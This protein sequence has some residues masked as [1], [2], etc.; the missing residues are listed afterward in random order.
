MCCRAGLGKLFKLAEDWEHM[1]ELAVSGYD[2]SGFKVLFVFPNLNLAT[3]LLP[4]ETTRYAKPDSPHYGIAQLAAVLQENKADVKILDMR[5]GYS[6]ADLRKVIEE[7]KPDLVGF[8]LI[9]TRIKMC[10]AM[11]DKVKELYPQIHTV[12]GGNH[13]A[14]FKGKV[15]EDCPGLDFGVKREGEVSFVQVIDA[16]RKGDK[17]YSQIK[18]ILY[19]DNGMVVMT[20]D[21]P[22]LPDLDVLPRPAYDLFELDQY[23][24]WR[25]GIVP[26]VT[27]R[28]CPF[29][30]V[31]CSINLTMGYKFRV[32][33]AKR[34]VED[35]TYWNKRGMVKFDINDDE[36]SFKRE[37][38][39]DI[40]QGIID[41]GL[42][43]ELRLF[44]GI[45]VSD[46][47]PEL[48]A[49]MK[50]AGFSAITYAIESGSPKVIKA[51]RKA[52]TIE[53]ALNAITWT[54]EAG[55]ETTV[56]FIIGHP[57]ETYEDALMTLE[58]MKTVPGDK[59]NFNNAVVYPSTELH[60]WV[61]EH[62]RFIIDPEEFLNLSHPGKHD[63]PF[64][65]TDD[66]TKEQ[67]EEILR[68]GLLIFRERLIR[69]RMKEPWA[70]MYV[71]AAKNDHVYAWG[72]ILKTSPFVNKYVKPILFRNY[73]VNAKR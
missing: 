12:A 65:E 45:R 28:G 21:M 50:E 51:I 66:F 53:Q 59:L 35:I 43:V 17:D 24:A 25:K 41:Q 64:F 32:H 10:Y 1:E 39:M 36:F 42:K 38:V 18:G 4:E 62:G 19:R 27:S 16:L 33:S 15:L 8:T 72:E 34:V 31:F 2:F 22:M 73:G 9:A 14:S 68:R 60:D 47:S 71:F 58:L 54:K 57:D 5:L 46:V 23:Y 56:N 6:F 11:I 40:C 3:N 52:I 63:V 7:Y 70:S 67:R 13:V 26:I 61:K 55:I 69:T 49:K 37:R 20:E 44:N 29:R 48:L 30:C